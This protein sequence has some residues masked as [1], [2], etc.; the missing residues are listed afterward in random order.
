MQK[1]IRSFPL[2]LLPLAFAGCANLE[3]VREFA[4]ISSESA[5]YTELVDDYARSPLRQKPF[6]PDAMREELDRMAAEREAQRADLLAVHG[7]MAEYMEALGRLAADETVVF[8]GEY[9]LLAGELRNKQILGEKEA[10]AYAKLAKVITTA[11]AD[12]WR[13]RKLAKIIENTHNDFQTVAGALRSIVD[14]DFRGSLENEKI[15][16]AKYYGGILAQARSQPPQQAG[17]VAVEEL[18]KEKLAAIDR[19]I[20]A[21]DMYAAILDK[22][23]KGHRALYDNRKNLKDKQTAKD[24]KRYS[25]DLKKA[26]K[27]LR[28]L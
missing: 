28:S 12:G 5:Q 16:A 22:I 6:Q 1:F 26:Y 11:A 4:S 14:G 2:F 10:D 15:A 19:E 27:E 9:D 18:L 13:R 23:Q 21:V 20:A 3:A 17:I 25:K 24:L 8:D 7:V